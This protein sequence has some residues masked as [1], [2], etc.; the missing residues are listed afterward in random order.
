ML[1]KL[2]LMGFELKNS[3]LNIKILMIV[4]VLPLLTVVL[5]NFAFSSLIDQGPLF[6]VGLVDKEKT[7]TSTYLIQEILKDDDIT[8]LINFVQV[9]EEQSLEKVQS[10]ELKG[11]FI[12]PENF[13]D[14]LIK[15][16]NT[17]MELIYKENDI[18]V[19]YAVNGISDSFSRYIQEVQKS[20]SATYYTTSKFENLKDHTQKIN[21]SISFIMISEIFNRKNGIIQN[22]LENIPTTT[23]GVYFLVMVELLIISFISLYFTYN[24][25]KEKLLNKKIQTVGFKKYEIKI[26]KMASY[27]VFINIQIAIIFV[28]IF[29]YLTEGISLKY[30]LFLNLI[31]LFLFSLW[32]LIS[33][34]IKKENIFISI[35]T[36]IIVTS[37]LFGGT[38][39]PLVLMPYNL[40]VVSKMTPNYWLGREFLYLI[41]GNVNII[42]IGIIIFLTTAFLY[43]SMKGD[44]IDA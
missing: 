10:G 4:I 17:P 40:Q 26:L 9:K 16:K 8:S 11:V 13:T 28:P 43:L 29:Y 21:N 32:F 5:F 1:K 36:L 14:N 37:N 25:K 31:S 30:I 35:S 7:P 24:Y 18:M 23:S 27:I 41:T 20:I 22:Q 15:M 38:L 34:L 39:F 44:G 33:S 12:I 19:A 2:K 3:I 42:N 6:D